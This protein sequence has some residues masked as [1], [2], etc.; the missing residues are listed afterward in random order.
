MRKEEQRKNAKQTIA[1][2]SSQHIETSSRAIGDWLMNLASISTSET[3]LSFFPI[4]GEVDLRLP[5]QTWLDAGKTLC[6]P[7]V[8][9]ETSTMQAAMIPSL[10]RETLVETRHGILEPKNRQAI[11]SESID[12]VL[13]P[14]LAFDRT[15]GRL[16]RGGGFYDRYLSQ[17]RPP[18]ALGVAFDEQIIDEVS[19]EPHD[20]KLTAIVTP[21]GLLTS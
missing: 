12:A 18:L 4:I 3:I 11:P 17:V 14:G 8:A 16:G 6:V 13:V 7:L 10:E 9:W 5:M 21:S 2:L 15:G 1:S 19:C 20:Y